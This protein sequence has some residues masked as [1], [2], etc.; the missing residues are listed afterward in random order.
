M[1]VETPRKV[2]EED[3]GRLEKCGFPRG[4]CS[5]G[6]NSLKEEE[7][8]AGEM[9]SPGFIETSEDGGGWSEGENSREEEEEEVSAGEK[10]SPG[11]IETSEDGGENDS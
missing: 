10:A 3:S 9:A 2:G 7:V 5:E 1:L 4:G 6:E 11:F 8:S